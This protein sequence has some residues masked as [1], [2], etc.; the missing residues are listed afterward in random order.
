M[1]TIDMKHAKAPLA[2]YARDAR[3]SPVVVT[4]RGRPV[5]VVVR[6][7]N[8]DLETISLSTNPKFLALIERSRA[9]HSKR[10]GMSSAEVRH[11]LGL[12]SE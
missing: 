6:I 3:K 12:K 1:T 11:R 5:A 8:A 2:K 9:R 4:A 7:E 10:G